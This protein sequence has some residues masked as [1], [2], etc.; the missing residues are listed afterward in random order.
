MIFTTIHNTKKV[1]KNGFTLVEL[2]VVVVIIGILAAIAVPIFLNQREKAADSTARSQLAVAAR[3]IY[4]GFNVSSQELE[5]PVTTLTPIPQSLSDVG[6][7]Y[8]TD[9][10]GVWDMSQKTFCI[11]KNYEGTLYMYDSIAN[12]VTTSTTGCSF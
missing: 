12:E 6:S 3:Y 1:G 11:Q 4:T 10:V 7:M 8:K 9:I 5:P 2:L